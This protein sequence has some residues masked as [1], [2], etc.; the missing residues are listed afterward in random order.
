MKKQLLTAACALFL[1]VGAANAQ[2]VIRIG[3]PPPRPVE[4]IPVVPPAHHDWVWVP[5][6]TAGTAMAT[7]GSPPSL[8]AGVEAQNLRISFM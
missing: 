8:L 4:V 2:I 5:G 7:S 3:P 6:S 1:T